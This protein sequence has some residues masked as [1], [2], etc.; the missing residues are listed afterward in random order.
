MAHSM[1][2]PRREEMVEESGWVGGWTRTWNDSDDSHRPLNPKQGLV[3]GLW[4]AR[5]VRVGL[6]SARLRLERL[7]RLGTHPRDVPGLLAAIDAHY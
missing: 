2:C 4:S 6:W 1:V 3:V 7:G 5:V